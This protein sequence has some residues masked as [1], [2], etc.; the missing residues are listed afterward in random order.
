[1]MNLFQPSV[2]LLRKKRVG[3]RLTRQYDAAQTP[4]DRLIV[5]KQ[6][7]AAKV[8]PLKQQRSRQDPFDLAAT[9]EQKIER[10]WGLANPKQS[11]HVKKKRG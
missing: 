5:S 4:L 10:I 2:K 9:I 7:D 1:M 8:Q 6:G 3:S 11:P